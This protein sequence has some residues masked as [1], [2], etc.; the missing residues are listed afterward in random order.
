LG[1]ADRGG[2]DAGG[3][4]LFSA[5]GGAAGQIAADPAGQ[6]GAVI[7]LGIAG[8]G[9]IGLGAKAG[10]SWWCPVDSAVARF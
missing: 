9:G 7:R 3:D 1:A 6:P 10:G 4:D 8:D 2:V 5:L